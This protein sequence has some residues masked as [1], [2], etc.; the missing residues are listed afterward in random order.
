MKR[1]AIELHLMPLFLSKALLVGA[2]AI[3]ETMLVPW[4]S[5]PALAIAVGLGL[6][7]AFLG[8]LGDSHFFTRKPA[9][10]AGSEGLR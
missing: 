9:M 3:A 5:N 2:A 6:A 4:L 7:V 10:L 8:P 1:E